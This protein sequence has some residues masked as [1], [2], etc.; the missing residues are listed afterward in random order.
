M[1]RRF[2]ALLSLGALLSA[3]LATSAS[4]QIYPN[5]PI[6]MIVPFA[7]GGSSDVIARLVAEEMSV[8][9][10][11]R[12][13]I[14]NVAG[15]GGAVGFAR[16]ASSPADGYFMAIGNAGTSAAT[17]TLDRTLKYTPDSFEP[18][19]MIAKTIPVIALK[20]GFPAKD[21]REFLDYATKNPGK[22]TLGHAGI[23]SSNYLICKLFLQASKV[24]I[25]L[26]GYRGAGPALNDAIGGH[27]DGICD[28]ATSVAASINGDKL[29]GLVTASNVRSPTLPQVQTAAEAGL[30][31]FVNEGWN[32]LLLPKG[33]PDV[34][35]KILN[36]AMRKSLES[37]RLRQR[38]AELSTLPTSS[39]EQDPG[40]TAKFIESEISKYRALLQ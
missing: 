8:V 24:K 13:V 36:D 35:K 34:I 20:K 37:P 9:L 25:E 21:L 32:V 10:K 16:L 5:R 7:P 26:A 3:V 15:A 17:Y 6:M 33:T 31:E 12:I 2:S 18:I 39:E 4:A 40:F 28:G 1:K 29:V 19:G 22:V 30:P 14:E 38:Y 11:E 23:G 27:I